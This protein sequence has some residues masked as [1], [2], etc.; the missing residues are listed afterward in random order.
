MKILDILKKEYIIRKTRDNLKTKDFTI[1]SQNQI[2]GMI[3]ND[4]K[5]TQLS[6]T[7]DTIISSTDFIKFMVI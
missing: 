6:P 1:L 7:I 3:Y 2:G 5:Q 4:M